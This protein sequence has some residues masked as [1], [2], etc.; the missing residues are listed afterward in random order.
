MPEDFSIH[1][2]KVGLKSKRYLIFI[3]NL[4][5]LLRLINFTSYTGLIKREDIQFESH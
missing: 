3:L 2:L 4:Q 5:W 1:E